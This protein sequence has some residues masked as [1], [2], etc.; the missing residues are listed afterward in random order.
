MEMEEGR[1]KG[2]KSVRDEHE[3]RKKE[4]RGKDLALE[5]EEEVWGGSLADGREVRD[6]RERGRKKV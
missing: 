6:G 2:R 4:R 5:E 3:R 1:K